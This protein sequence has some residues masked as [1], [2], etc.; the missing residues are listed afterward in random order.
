LKG[1]NEN[2][3]IRE[4]FRS[5]LESSE[6]VPQVG[7]RDELMRK[8]VVKEFLH[9]NFSHFNVYYSALILAG[10]VA[11]IIIFSTRPAQNKNPETKPVMKTEIPS[12]KDVSVVQGKRI[13]AA[14]PPKEKK[15]SNSQGKQSSEKL[16]ISNAPGSNAITGIE[17]P[18][19]RI[20][21]SD[22]VPEQEI[23][24]ENITDIHT[25]KNNLIE[26]HKAIEASFD[27]SV[28]SGCS[29]LKV[30]FLNRSTSFDSCQWVFGDGGYST[31]KDPEWIFDNAGE[32]KIVLTVFDSSGNQAAV[33]SLI[34]V[35]PRPDARF[36]TAPEKPVIPDDEI[37]FMNLSIDAVGYRWEF[38]DGNTS[39][40]FEPYH[41]YRK[42]NK[43]NVG[44]IVWS[45]YG[46]SDTVLVKNAFSESGCYINFPNAFI[47]GN[48]GPVGGYYST[49]SDESARIFHPTT[50]GVNEYQLRVF[51]KIGILIFESNDINVGWDGYMKGHLCEPGVY[52]WK[53]RG[54]FNNG[55]PFLKTGDVTL[56]KN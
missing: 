3:S 22:S 18:V 39:G 8:L 11:G 5:K 17:K 31:K 41:K 28:T 23:P 26:L 38:G 42:Y 15:G 14:K 37:H 54:S 50:S 20:V 43:Y 36:E 4:L 6:V 30:K 21:E 16:R 53:V 52:V 47:P 56:I 10:A 34:T 46:C 45:E 1:G 25:L 7:V 27:A 2:M 32:Y 51:S 13:F 40:L 33:S 55:E 24:D 44:L 9:F 48:D 19:N 29:P 49:K 12:V 35:H